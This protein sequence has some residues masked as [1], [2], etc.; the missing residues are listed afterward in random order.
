[1]FKV[2]TTQYTR[3]NH[4]IITTKQ[5]LLLFYDW[6]KIYIIENVKITSHFH[7]PNNINIEI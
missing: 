4:K 7:D 3:R 2:T 1:M 6:K 5:L